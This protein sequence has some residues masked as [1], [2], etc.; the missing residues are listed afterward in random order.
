[1]RPG[2]APKE[3]EVEEVTA[4]AEAVAVAVDSEAK[5]AT[6]IWHS[7]ILNISQNLFYGKFRGSLAWPF[8]SSR[9]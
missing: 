8:G 5:G 2:L 6:D 9:S 4:E 1:M 3:V 7:D